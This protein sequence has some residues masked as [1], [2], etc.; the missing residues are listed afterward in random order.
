MNIVLVFFGPKNITFHNILTQKYRTYLPVCVCAECPPWGVSEKEDLTVHLLIGAGNLWLLQKGSTIRGEKDQP[1]AIDTFLGWTLS[2]PTNQEGI[3]SQSARVNVTITS[4]LEKLEEQKEI[5]ERT[6]HL[7]HQRVIRESVEDERRG[8]QEG[9]LESQT[10]VKVVQKEVQVSGDKLI[11]EEDKF[12]MSRCQLKDK[13][14]N[15][16][17][18]MRVERR[19]DSDQVLHLKEECA[20]LKGEKNEGVQLENKEAQ[21]TYDL[22]EGQ[23]IRRQ[24]R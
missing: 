11:E 17:E 16:L 9:S 5:R 18:S 19:R 10:S 15:E 21:E 8:T 22:V 24:I 20:L 4:Q 6:N 12:H 14:E 3:T 1:V 7:S 23:E 2:G 13:H